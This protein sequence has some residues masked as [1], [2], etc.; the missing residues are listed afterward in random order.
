[1]PFARR[2]TS[3]SEVLRQLG[4]A[5]GGEAGS[6]L[7]R[8]LQ[9]IV[10]GDTV[11][12]I[13]RQITFNPRNNLMV[14]EIDDWAFAKGRRYGT[15]LVDLERGVPVDLL[16]DRTTATL[17]AWLQ[18]HPGIEVVT[19]YRF[20]D[21]AL[22]VNEVCPTVQQVA[23]RWHLLKNLRETLERVLRRLHERLRSLPP[24][25]ELLT[26]TNASRPRRLR[27]PSANEQANTDASRLRRF[28]LY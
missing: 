15:I 5:L 25:A 10:S 16:P 12:R 14:V 27:P 13:L 2:S 17:A 20:I 9:M 21:Y 8:Q 3:L 1:M 6:R 7:A 18:A 28:Q 11:L 4:L 22:A 26:V 19:L 23:D 24:S